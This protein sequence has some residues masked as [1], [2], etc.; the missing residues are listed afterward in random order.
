M[1]LSKYKLGELIELRDVR[2]SDLQYSIADVRGVNNLKLL[3]PT[4]A[5]LN[6]R[7]LTKFQI[8]SPGEFVFNHRTSRN[9]SKFSIAYNDGKRPIICTEDYVV[10]RVKDDCKQILEAI[11]LYMFFNRPEFDRYVITNSWG[12][13]TEF[14]NWEDICS[15]SLNLPSIG[16]QQKYV[17]VYNAMLANQQSYEHGL[18][19]LKLT[20]DAYI[21]ELR[22]NTP[23]VA[24]G[25]YLMLSDERNTL[26]LSAN[27]VRGLSVS[28]DMIETKA[29]MDGVNI[30]NY[31]I[32][33]PRYIAYVSDTSRRGDKMSLGFNRT[34]E[35]FL[36]SSIS[37]VFKTDTQY[38]LPE[39]L[40]LYICRDEFDRYARFHSWGSARETF[41][42]G[43]MCDVRIPI[44]SIEIQQDIVNIYESYLTRKEIN[45]KLKTQIKDLCPILIKGSIEEAQK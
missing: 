28:K 9:G 22:R 44:P 7:D 6:G 39:F 5:D 2:N 21:E 14:Y 40:M 36:V 15:I 45:E 26:N 13:S 17:A 12:S 29:N 16:I 23:S 37:T 42:W 30:S 3:M 20:C 19:D 43:E 33:P 10:F 11:W 31:K 35:T 38:L 1:G 8:V 32:I 18:E 25:K 34:E 41:D 4:K 24:I 27:S